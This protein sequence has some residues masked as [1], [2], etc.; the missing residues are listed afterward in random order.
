MHSSIFS[1]NANS[2]LPKG[3]WQ[4]TWL[5]TLAMVIGTIAGW[6]IYCRQI[7]FT[8]DGVADTGELWV[9]ARK[10]ASRVGENGVILVGASRIQLG[11]NTSVMARYANTHPVQL[12]LDGS[13]FLQVLENLA[14][15]PT[16][17]GTV[18]VDMNVGKISPKITAA[19]IAPLLAQYESQKKISTYGAIQP[20]EERLSS[21][22]DNLLSYRIT[23][24]KPHTFITQAL[25]NEA[26]AAG[27]YLTTL[28][29]RS[30]HAD[31]TKVPQP[32]FYLARLNRN[33]GSS[34]LD[35]LKLSHL[36]DFKKDAEHLET[37]VQK[38]KQRKGRV[39]F[40]R[41][42]TDKGIW[43]IDETRLPKRQYWDKLAQM[44]SAET[45]HF[46]DYPELSRFDQPDGSHLDYRDAIPFTE[47]LSR[48]IFTAHTNKNKK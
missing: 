23:G 24:A 10:R 28:P 5:L 26:S 7:G 12:A 48:I 40:V 42:P 36:P 22:M 9:K 18:I 19:H 16:I 17:K 31:Y 8:P 47:A 14:N 38:I 46:K 43:Q 33:L 39:V 27:S 30:R 35:A 1:S 6:E 13:P 2:R 21:A 32:D 11:I 41:F 34:T 44:T 4:L 25:F 37:L 20:L 3:Q 45:I 29:D 15:D